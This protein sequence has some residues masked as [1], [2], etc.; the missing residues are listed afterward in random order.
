MW[1]ASAGQNGKMPGADVYSSFQ[2]EYRRLLG[3]GY[4]FREDVGVNVREGLLAC[5]QQS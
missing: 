5:F 2:M 3:L 1:I 4:F